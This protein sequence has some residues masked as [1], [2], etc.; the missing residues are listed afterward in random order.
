MSNANSCLD[1]VMD[2]VMEPVL[3]FHAHKV[4]IMRYRMSGNHSQTFIRCV[5]AV[6][7]GQAEKAFRDFMG[8]EPGKYFLT[9][10]RVISERD[11]RT[12][13]HADLLKNMS[14]NDKHS[15]FCDRNQR[16]VR[17]IGVADDITERHCEEFGF[18]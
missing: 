8:L 14:S 7:Y 13:V 11:F 15:F 18:H 5:Y 4:F 3:D 16:Q 17:E 10:Y 9:G 2:S 1:S 12:H 6:N